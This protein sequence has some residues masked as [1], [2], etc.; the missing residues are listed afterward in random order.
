MEIRGPYGKDYPSA[1]N[2]LAFSGQRPTL[3]RPGHLVV[4][5]THNCHP[6]LGSL[7]LLNCHR[8]VYPLRFGGPERGDDWSLAD[9]CDQC[10]RKGGLV[11]W[12]RTWHES[13]AFRYGEPLADLVLGKIDAFEIDFFEDSPFDSLPDWYRL[14]NAGLRVPLVGGSGKDSNDLVLGSMR[15]FAHLAVG[16]DFAY[17]PWIE[18][19]RAGRTFVT[20]GPLI[21]LNVAGMGPGNTIELPTETVHVHAE[22]RGVVPLDRLE[23]LLN[24]QLVGGASFEG[25]PTAVAVF[26][27]EVRIPAGGWLAARCGSAHQLFTQPGNQRVF[28]HTSPIYLQRAGHPVPVDP[29]ALA[30]FIRDLDH[31]LEWTASRGRFANDRQRERLAGIY[32]AARQKLIDRQT[33]AG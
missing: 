8:V 3:E 24:G 32:R 20:N 26:D 13:T 14:L 30:L 17:R 9:W 21:S 28:A 15:T 12:T 5:N 19:L 29:A 6:V 2:L 23:I 16:E 10:H 18:A 27:A 22:A 1:P 31:L 4:V 33:A 7:G 11:T 25:S